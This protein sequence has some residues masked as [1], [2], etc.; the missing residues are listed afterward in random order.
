M[1][2]ARRK[3]IENAC[4]LISQAREIIT[5]AFDE[6]RAKVREEFGLKKGA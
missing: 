1:N 4:E 3:A 6:E 5:E 2:K